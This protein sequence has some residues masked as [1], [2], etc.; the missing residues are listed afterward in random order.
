MIAIIITIIIEIVIAII[1]S[2]VVR[3]GVAVVVIVATVRWVWSIS[4]AV[5]PPWGRTAGICRIRII[6]VRWHGVVVIV[7]VVIVVVVVPLVRV[8]IVIDSIV[9]S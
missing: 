2:V 9:S 6:V 4:A 3:G 8:L 5:V 1:W 7:I